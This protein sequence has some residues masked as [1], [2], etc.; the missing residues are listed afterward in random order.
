MQLSPPVKAYHE[1]TSLD[2]L[3]EKI[4]DHAKTQGYAVTR[5]RSKQSKLEILMKE[6][7]LN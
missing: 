7:S 6:G 4:N 5:K 3:I 2:L 1:F